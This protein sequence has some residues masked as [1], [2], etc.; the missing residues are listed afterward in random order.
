MKVTMIG[1]LHRISGYENFNIGD[2]IPKV[3]RGF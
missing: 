3:A 2:W 1:T